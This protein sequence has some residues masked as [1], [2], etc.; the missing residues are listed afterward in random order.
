M[1]CSLANKVPQLNTKKESAHKAIPKA[2]LKGIANL[3]PSL[4]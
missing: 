4:P 1:P 2:N 3:S